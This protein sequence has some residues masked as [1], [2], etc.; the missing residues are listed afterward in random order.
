MGFP[1]TGKRVESTCICIGRFAGG[2]IAE[3]WQIWDA[4]GFFKQLAAEKAAV[5]VA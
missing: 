5:L 4:Q 1:P 3:E 2:K